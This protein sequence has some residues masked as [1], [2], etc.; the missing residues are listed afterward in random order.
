[1]RYPPGLLDEIRAR[2]PVS[3]V[4]ARR[5][6][7]K[8]QGRE[9]I[10]LSPFKVEKTPSFTVNDQKGFYHC[11]ATG[12]HG[13]IFGFVM[14]TEGLSFPEAVERLAQEAG[15]SLPKVSV[16]SEAEHDRRARFMAA[17][18]AACALFEA[19]LYTPAG[20]EALRYADGRGLTR[21]TLRRFR[22]G[23]APPGRNALKDHLIGAGYTLD[24]L[25]GAGLVVS[26]PDIATP[27]DR[28]RNRL[29][30]PITDMKD[31][32]VAFGGR[33]LDAE[34]KPKYLNSPETPLFHKGGLLFNAAKAR[35]PSHD[36][37]QLLVV[38]G[39]MDAIA[40]YQAGFQEV[41]APLG[42]ALTPD[43]LGLLWRM[44]EEPTL[45]FDGDSAGRRAAYRAVDT[46]LPLLTPGH[47]LK[48]AFLPDG[49]DPDDL[50]RLEGSDR[51]QTVLNHA[52]PLSDVL[53]EK[54]YAAGTWSTPE[55]R[56]ALSKQINALVAR[57]GEPSVRGYYAQ[58]MREKLSQAFSPV[59][60]EPSGK[61]EHQGRNGL[62][63]SSRSRRF[64]SRPFS[65]RGGRSSG[66]LFGAPPAAA[67]SRSLLNSRLVSG[68][69][70]DPNPR[71]IQ[72]VKAVINHPWLIDEHAEAIAELQ[73]G[74][75]SIGA[76]RDAALETH[77]LL[78]PLDR[79]RMRDQ[80]KESGHER[81]LAMLDRAISHRSDKFAEPDAPSD[82]VCSGFRQALL[83]Q[84]CGVLRL[85]IEAAERSWRAEQS[86]TAYAALAALQ[87]R[88]SE[89]EGRRAFIEGK[90]DETV[91]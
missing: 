88:L 27:Y 29:I 80:L 87:Q 14:K 56:A 82:V 34:T 59:R 26:G 81:A 2:L 30:F 60:T 57:I 83:L 5:V 33:A 63:P 85:E 91:P 75:R 68:G 40:L 62:G 20:R 78:S 48:F 65:S 21:D 64:A 1:M 32:V 86:D 70:S 66:G 8:R 84:Q 67:P 7:L 19:Q 49:L 89:V 42:T 10:G 25:I 58:A 15:V 16:R 37:G 53:W 18:E 90:G 3:Q 73:L 38:E 4:V 46:A 39:Y 31:R 12:E 17:A 55:R 11:F 79:T 45:C 69:S 76:L 52:L 50:I 77:A 24:E 71:E 36:R 74:G 9:Y 44:C 22:I 47:S 51:M 28:F 23:F 43:Q 72:L 41:V 54:E 35:G 6:R 61:A 13:D